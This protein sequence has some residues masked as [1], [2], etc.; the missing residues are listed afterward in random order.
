MTVV[1]ER[2]P[3]RK[4]ATLRTRR[5][6]EVTATNGPFLR[7]NQVAS[8]CP[9]GGIDNAHT[10]T[11]GSCPRSALPASCFGR[12][13]VIKTLSRTIWAK[14]GVGSPVRPDLAAVEKKLGQLRPDD[15]SLPPHEARS[16]LREN[17]GPLCAPVA[18]V[19]RTPSEV[20]RRP[21]LDRKSRDRRMEECAR[22]WCGIVPCPSV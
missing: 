17:A 3:P 10:L 11:I 15:P 18:A 12:A 20:A 8:I 7:H 2:R 6:R 22:C 19:P 1:G 14:A 21:P 5:R 4:A 13:E 16:K 9:R